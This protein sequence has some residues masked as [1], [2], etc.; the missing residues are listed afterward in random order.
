M[1]K[2]FINQIPPEGGRKYSITANGD[3][4][5]VIKDVTQYIEEGTPWSAEDANQAMRLEDYG[6]SKTGVVKDSDKFG[7]HVPT[8]YGKA[9]V[10]RTATIGTAWEG[11]ASPY[12]QTVAVAGILDSDCPHISPVY[13]ADLDIALAQ[14]DAWSMI[15]RADTQAGAIVFKC[16]EDKPE[17]EIPVQIEVL[18]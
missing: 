2:T 5:S 4:T 3:G 17:V 9:P 13:D 7:G 10:R 18:R 15:S 14:R 12:T 1:S 16:F 8:Y 11:A 6:G